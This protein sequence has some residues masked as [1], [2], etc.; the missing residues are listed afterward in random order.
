MYKCQKCN[1]QVPANN[2]ANKVITKLRKVS[3]T[4][5]VQG[6]YKEETKISYGTEVVEE[7]SLCNRCA[8]KYKS[9]KP[10][11]IER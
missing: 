11:V 2:T 6:K 9:I 8:N 10:L 5:K 1:Y 4:N 7:L 3:Y